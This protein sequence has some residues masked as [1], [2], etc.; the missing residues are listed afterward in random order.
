MRG[1]SNFFAVHLLRPDQGNP[2]VSVLSTDNTLKEYCVAQG[3]RGPAN[4]RIVKRTEAKADGKG[5]STKPV[6]LVCAIVEHDGGDGGDGGGGGGGGNDGSSKQ[7]KQPAPP[8]NGRLIEFVGDSDT[9]TFGLL[10]GRT[11]RY[12]VFSLDPGCQ[13]ADLGW[14]AEVATFFGAGH[15][16]IS[17]SGIG[18]T[19]NAPGCGSTNMRAAYPR[20]VARD[21]ATSVLLGG[22]PDSRGS[23]AGSSPGSQLKLELPGGVDLVIM[24]IGGNDWW[25][26]KKHGDEAF[27]DGFVEL[28]KLVKQLRPGVPI[29]V[30]LANDTSGS[31]CKDKADQKRFSDD[32]TRLLTPAV[33]RFQNAGDHGAVHLRLVV[34]APP[35]EFADSADWGLMGHWSEQGASKWARGVIPHVAEIMEWTGGGGPAAAQGGDEAKM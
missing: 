35:I 19:W 32:M 33:D 10:G 30:L 2:D 12:N 6:E 9:A 29:L 3:V 24:Y 26:L 1:G 11:A 23:S 18:H 31:C 17:W 27:I 13:A 14:A 21:P 8:C 25:S 15:H 28:V 20:L 4:I 34:P 5:G 16:N 22:G 7:G